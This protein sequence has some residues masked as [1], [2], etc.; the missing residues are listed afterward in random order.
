MRSRIRHSILLSALLLTVLPA[1]AHHSMSALFDFNQ[2]FSRT[3]TL[4]ELDWRNPHI[5]LLVEAR[6]ADG[7]MQTWAFEGPSPVFFRNR[8]VA[9]K[10]D[11]V[12][13]IEKTVVVEA[14]RARDGSPSG[15][16]RSIT[17]ANGKF[18]P[19]CPDNC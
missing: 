1:A 14:S 13:S 19:L 3:G 16:I 7:Q 10:S 9:S 12:D 5:Y 11:F 8:E 15:L 4:S 6:E 17:L 2:R 18:V